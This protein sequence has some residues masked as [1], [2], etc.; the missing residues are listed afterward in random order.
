M[1]KIEKEHFKINMQVPFRFD[2]RGEISPDNDRPI[3]I[4]ENNILMLCQ[5][6]ISLI[7][8]SIDC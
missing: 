5:S 2:I 8:K 1:N 4:V 6:Q 7:M 3:Y